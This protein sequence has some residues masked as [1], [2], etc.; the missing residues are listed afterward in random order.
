MSHEVKKE[1]ES[2]LSNNDAEKD[3]GAYSAIIAKFADYDENNIP[4]WIYDNLPALLKDSCNVFNDKYEKDI[5]LTGTLS[6]L[7]GCFHNLYAYNEVDKKR[8]ATNLLAIIVGPAASGKGALNYSKK[9]AQTIKA[10]FASNS[11]KLNSKSGNKLFIPANISSSGMIQLLAKNNG[12]GIMVESEIDTIVNA[13]RQEW[14]NYSEIIRKSFENEEYSMYRKGKEH[15]EFYD[16]ESLRL[17]IAISGTPHQFK[18]LIYSTENGLFSRG[19]YYVFDPRDEKLVFTGRMNSNVTLD[20]KFASFA[21]IANDYYE[22]HLAFHEIQV[23]MSKDQLD[24]IGDVLQIV[25]ESPEDLS[26][27][28]ANIKRA[29][30][31]AQKI[32]AILTLLYEC[33][34]GSLQETISCTKESLDTAIQLTLIYLVHS[35][36]AYEL[37]PSRMLESLNDT[38]QRLLLLLS[39]EFTRSEGVQVGVKNGMKQRIVYYAIDD[40]IRKGL[41]QL[42]PSGKYKRQ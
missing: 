14:G 32:A 19:T 1:E 18:Q 16:I 9:I 35:Y 24:L 41:I 39:E 25:K 33:Q 8:V 23:V 36:N 31:M 20:S 15:A 12:V 22:L 2:P 28:D 30:I 10:T 3:S 17:S 27:L 42:L 7:G 11:R 26:N 37:L 29:F 4:Q 13:N 38:Q 5:F 21:R 6:V 40:L 34:S